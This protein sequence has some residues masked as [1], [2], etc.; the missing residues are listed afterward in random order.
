VRRGG[1]L[2][3]VELEPVS[4]WAIWMLLYDEWIS[5]NRRRVSELSDDRVGYLHI[6]S[7]NQRAVDDF[8]R[9]LFA[10]GLDREGLIVD[11][12]GN[13]GGS[14]HD[15][16]LSR[17][18]RT[19]YAYSR[20]RWGTPSYEPLGVWQKP[21]VLLIDET[22]YSDAEIFPSGWKELGLGPIVGMPTYGAVIGTNDV[23]LVDGTGFRLPSSGWYTLEG[24]NLENSG[25]TP[26]I[27]VLE[28][29]ADEA[30]G[31]DRQLD[32]AVQVI[33]EEIGG[34]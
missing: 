24:G 14:T 19:I 18:D 33:M 13:G 21:L 15:Q 2:I 16:I 4:S 31:V 32:R 26:D 12:R 9:D 22:C 6:R 17:L 3:E 28:L 23:E 8:N 29:P 30:L 1:E 27:L 34:E 5:R 11:V 10:E 20:D 25:V 7:M